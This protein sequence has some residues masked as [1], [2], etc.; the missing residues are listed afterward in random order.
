MSE[1]QNQGEDTQA[2]AGAQDEEGGLFAAA[3]EGQKRDAEGKPQK[4]DFL[5]DGLWDAEKGAPR[6][7]IMQSWRDLRQKISK[8]EG[9]GAP[10]K[11]EAYELPKVEGL[12]AVPLDDA[13]FKDV[14]AAAHKAGVSAAQF[15]AI[16]EPILRDAAR[17]LGKQKPADAEAA[18]AEAQAAYEAEFAKLGPNG[19][20][21]VQDV[22]GWLKGLEGRGLLNKAQRQALYG[23]SS[24]DGMLALARLREL[25]GD[26]PV[27]IDAAMTGDNATEADA[28]AALRAAMRNGDPLAMKSAMA[29]LEQMEA[30]GRLRR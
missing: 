27:P 23:I 24:A 21:L 6:P 16:A 28:R 30:A 5:P 14:R 13:V 22:G 8:G 1:T 9:A 18:Q 15:A 25:A 3:G 19:R 20:Q 11:P 29:K 17:R 2:G 26:R 4:P 12:P 10:D 7:E